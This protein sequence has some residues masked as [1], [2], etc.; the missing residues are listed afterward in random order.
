VTDEKKQKI[1]AFHVARLLRC[2]YW[3]KYDI[4]NIIHS[5]VELRFGERS[6]GF[7]ET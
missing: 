1:T 3:K 6:P 4:K 5:K 2:P 7:G